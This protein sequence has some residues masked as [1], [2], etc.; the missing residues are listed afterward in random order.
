MPTSYDYASHDGA[1]VSTWV[2]ADGDPVISGIAQGNAGLRI[3]FSRAGAFVLKADKVTV[4]SL[5]NLADVDRRIL[6]R[7]RAGKWERDWVLVSEVARG[8]PAITV[9]SGSSDGEA[10]VDLGVTAAAVGQPLAAAGAGIALGNRRGLAGYFV[11]LAETPLLWRG[12]TVRD[13]WWSSKTWMSER[14]DPTH[15]ESPVDGPGPHVVEIE[16]LEDIPTGER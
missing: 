7:H 8:G 6:A 2:A 1:Q 14:G 12:R 11:S 3:R 9:V 16:H 13:P 4:Q 10:F 15:E 5:A